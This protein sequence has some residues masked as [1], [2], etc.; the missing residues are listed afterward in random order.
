[1]RSINKRPS[2]PNYVG[3][4]PQIDSYPLAAGGAP[5]LGG[6]NINMITQNFL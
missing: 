2:N 3:M 5:S 1:M 6:G 4:E